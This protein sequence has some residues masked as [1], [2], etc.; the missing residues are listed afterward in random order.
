MK[1]E[2]KSDILII[3]EKSTH[4]RALVLSF[5]SVLIGIIIGS[6]LYN[7]PDFFIKDEAFSLFVD[8]NTDITD[9]TNVEVFSGIAIS[10]LLYFFIMFTFGGNIFGKELTLLTT[11]L[12]ASGLGVLVSFLYDRY[13]A[14]GFEYTLLVLIPGKS[15][16]FFS[17]L[18]LSECCFE[19]STKLRCGI[20]NNDVKRLIKMFGVKSFIS[21]GV[22]LI[23][24]V[25]DYFCITGLSA[26]VSFT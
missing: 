9:K 11:A 24:W 5:I 4:K 21:L 13:G 18:F 6:V 10:C 1:S 19:A 20:N 17:M 16:L 7:L 22:M 3:F 15:I 12:K 2:F 25:I 8:F 26:L 23:S 14:E